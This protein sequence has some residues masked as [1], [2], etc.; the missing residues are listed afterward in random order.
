MDDLNL[1]KTVNRM[2]DL[3]DEI[4]RLSSKA[5]LSPEQ[6][7]QLVEAHEEFTGL[8]NHRNGLIREER[9]AEVRNV[10]ANVPGNI[11]KGDGFEEDPIGEPGSAVVD[12]NED[13]WA[14]DDMRARSL[15]PGAWTEE[16]RAR[17]LSAVEKMPGSTDKRRETSADLVERYPSVARYALATTS[18]PYQRA[19][20]KW[21]IHGDKAVGAYTDDEQQAVTRAMSLTDSAGGYMI[22]FQLDPTVIITTDGSLNEIRQVARQVI[23]TGDVWNGV[24]AGATTWSFDTEAA[25]VS[26]DASTFVQPTV[27]IHKA[28]GFVPISIEALADEANVTQEVGRLLAFGKDDL[29]A[30]SFTTGSGSD[31]PWGVVVAV[32]AEATGSAGSDVFAIADVY[33]LYGQ[34]PARYRKRGSWMAHNVTYSLIRAFDTSG[35]S[36]LWTTFAQERPATL[37]GRPVVENEA[38]DETF[39]SGENYTL[40]LGDFDN[41][42]IADRIGMTVELIP[43][44]FDTTT[45]RPSGQR[46]IYAYYRVGSDSV[47]DSAF[48]LLNI[49]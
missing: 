44:M 31:Q 4:E 26:D 27:A 11:H 15:D 14:I 29:E 9:L 42:V 30:T 43:H 45:N 47:N 33:K 46:G 32:T 6:D 39:G 40:L 37:L 3:V 36:G 10:M 28:Q 5:D 12:R 18:P 1:Q 35:G 38:M 2:K 21:L 24:A 34:L 7:I 22:P 41:F 13:P 19:F 17:A 16:I 23:A 20:T 8:E 49:T 48:E 25:E